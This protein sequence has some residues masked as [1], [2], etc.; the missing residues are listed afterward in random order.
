V[1]LY[2]RDEEWKLKKLSHV[3]IDVSAKTFTVI[4][5]HEGVRT[6]AFDLD[7]DSKGHRALIRMITKKGRHARVVLEATGVYSLD[8]ALA[9]HRAKRV[10][11]MVAN[12]RAIGQFAGAYLRR[13]KTDALDANIIVEFAIR[14]DFQAWKP[15]EAHAFNLRAISRRISGVIKMATQEKNRLH[16]A[17]SFDEMSEVVRNDIEVNLRHLE[18]RVERLR[19]QARELIREYPDLERAFLHITSVKGIAEASAIQ[20]LAELSVLPKDMDVRQWVAHAGLDPRVFQSGTSVNKPARI[21]R[22]GNVHIRRAL[23][24]PALVAVQ[25]EPHVKAFYEKLLGRGK[26]KMQAN[27]AVMRKLLHAIHGML[28]HD[29]DFNGEKFY[30]IGA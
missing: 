5:D 25:Y 21:S 30:V 29:R 17:T 7:N 20:I 2:T 8:L 18:R 6:D 22:Q 27:V 1:P 4:I 12:P 9:L 19:E 24:M 28:K 16:A 14:M 13:S 11:V 23:F 26:T 15:P 10:E 3:G